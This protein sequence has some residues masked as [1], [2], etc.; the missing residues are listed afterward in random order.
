MEVDMSLFA[1]GAIFY[2]IVLL[3]G[4][5]NDIIERKTKVLKVRRKWQDQELK[6]K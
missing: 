1:A 2:L 5:F 4:G 3:L 6:K